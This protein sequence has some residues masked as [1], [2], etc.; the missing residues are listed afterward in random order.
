MDK[1]LAAAEDFLI[2][3]QRLHILVRSDSRSC[4]QISLFGRLAAVTN[5]T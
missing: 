3:E 5:Q 1:L 4:S 2:S